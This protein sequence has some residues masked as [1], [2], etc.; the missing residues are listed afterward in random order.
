MKIAKLYKKL[1]LA[2]FI[3]WFAM[4][5]YR[6]AKI[7]TGYML[8]IAINLNPRREIFQEN[9]DS[10]KINR[11]FFFRKVALP[12]LSFLE[13]CKKLKARI[14][15]HKEGEVI[16]LRLPKVIN[17]DFKV[18]E[19]YACQAKLPDVYL[20][21]ISDA[22]IFVGT[23][24]IIAD[25][26][27]LYDQINKDFV[28]RYP[29]K[30]PLI[31]NVSRDIINI[32][33]PLKSAKIKHGIHL[34]KDHAKNYFH[35]LIEN[36]PRLSLISE[37]DKNI[38]LLVDGDLPV[39]FYD[40]LAMLNQDD[41]EII[42]LNNNTLYKVRKLYYPSQ[43][44]I[45]HDSYNN[46]YYGKDA[47]YSSKAINYVR[48]AVLK[49]IGSSKNLVRRRKLFISRKNSD[50]RQ[51]INSEE[52]EEALV[53]RGFEIIF[54]EH[55]SLFTQVQLFSEAELIVGQ[56]GA[57]MANFIFAP[58]DCEIL[59]MM[60][61]ASQSNLHIFGALADCMGFSLKYILGKHINIKKSYINHSDFVVDVSILI[62][63][64]EGNA[65]DDRSI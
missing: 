3:N 18:N 2:N 55:L 48:E 50:Y 13:G 7:V 16:E 45:F 57:G 33:W 20:A 28:D 38:P 4:R 22:Q 65:H 51:L 52:I 21:E 39:Q 17:E 46:P 32:K 29:I 35:W 1:T 43:L 42:K 31:A 59:M 14:I 49:K 53:T 12:Y 30:S 58:K 56:S 8:I 37:L 44:S 6:V 25:K 61:D 15:S 9:F 11:V 63:Y 62:K 27:I 36:L 34:P 47:V 19:E 40:A 54:P 23:D 10:L 26:T 64:L 5:F 60:S 24:L 41:R